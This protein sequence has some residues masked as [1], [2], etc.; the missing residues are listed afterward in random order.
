MGH[1]KVRLQPVVE[2]RGIKCEVWRSEYIQNN[3]PALVLLEVGTGE[4]I[5]TATA[6]LVEEDCKPNQTYI[7]DYAENSGIFDVLIAAG[8]VRDTGVKRFSGYCSF[9][10]VDVLL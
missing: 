1:K 3:R 5:L 2:F 10:L 8:V 6:N 7:K 4:P 9:P